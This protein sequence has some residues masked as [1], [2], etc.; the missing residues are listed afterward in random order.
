MP[1]RLTWC[2]V[3]RTALAANL[4]EFRRRVGPG[5]RLAPV[6]KANAYGHGLVGASR[7]FAEA[8]ADLLCVN[9]LWEAGVLRDA[10]LTLPLHVVGRVPPE[11]AAEAVALGVSLVVYDR[12]V[13]SALDRA[14]TA[15]GRRVEVHL[16]IET[17]THRQGVDLEDARRLATFVRGLGRV[18]L[19]GLSTHFADIEDTTDHTYAREQLARFQAACDALR[20]DGFALTACNVGNSAATILWPEAHLDLVRIGIA[21]YGM[22]PSKETYVAA[23]LGHREMT[24]RAALTWKTRVAQVKDVQAGEYVGYGRTFRTTA[25]ARIAV[26][27]VGYYDGYDRGL[28][29]AYVLI[30]GMRAQVRG[31]VCMNMV[32]V[33]VTDIPGTAAGDEVVLLG[34]QDADAITTDQFASW[35]GTINYEV[36][37]RIAESVPRIVV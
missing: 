6:V 22:W 21:A 16:K 18:D 25:L 31:R 19:T 1:E 32:M 36:T 8:G 7:V 24:L 11:Q 26:L 34:A 15:A 23:A 10:G 33:D 37:T 3:S 4:A 28:A 5:C 9:D 2:E 12:D 13:L 29:N 27:P 14:A 30:R 17:G 35:A 20:R